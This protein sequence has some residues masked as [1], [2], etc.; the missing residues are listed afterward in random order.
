L[1]SVIHFAAL[2]PSV[3]RTIAELG[4]QLFTVRLCVIT[5]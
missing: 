2:Q 1:S 3:T 4:A 5:F